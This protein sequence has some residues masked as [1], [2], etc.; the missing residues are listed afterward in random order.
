MQPI[1][2][3][4]LAKRIYITLNLDIKEFIKHSYG[5]DCFG[6]GEIKL[7]PKWVYGYVV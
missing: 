2:N 7:F 4:G 1:S 6:D 3:D 5:C